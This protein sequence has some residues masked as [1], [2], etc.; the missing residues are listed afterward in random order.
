MANY[1]KHRFEPFREQ[2][3]KKEDIN[4]YRLYFCEDCH[5]WFSFLQFKLAEELKWK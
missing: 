1:C 4:K 3:P 5:R 2:N